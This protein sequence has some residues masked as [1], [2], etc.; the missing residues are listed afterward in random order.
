MVGGLLCLLFYDI[1]RFGGLLLCGEFHFGRF[2]LCSLFRFGRLLF[3]G[4]SGFHRFVHYISDARCDLIGALFY[5]RF[6]R[7]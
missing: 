2:L 3:R 1:G 4:V 5:R 7:F 6:G